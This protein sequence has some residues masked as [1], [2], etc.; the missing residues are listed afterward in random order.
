MGHQDRRVFYF[1]GDRE[2]S[3]NIP[4]GALLQTEVDGS[5]NI[6]GS[7]FKTSFT[8]KTLRHQE[9]RNKKMMGNFPQKSFLGVLVPSW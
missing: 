8:T 5:Q 6:T 1:F 7:H 9:N 2:G 3:P 4:A